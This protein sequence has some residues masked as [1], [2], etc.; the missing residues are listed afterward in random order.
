MNQFLMKD[1]IRE[2]M[3]NCNLYADK[4]VEVEQKSKRKL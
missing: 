4:W 2:K 3:K 1:L